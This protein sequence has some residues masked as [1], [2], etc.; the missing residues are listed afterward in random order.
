MRRMAKLPNGS[1]LATI[2]PALSEFEQAKMSKFNKKS[3][4]IFN[5]KEANSYETIN[6][7]SFDLEKAKGFELPANDL[8]K[9]AYADGSV[10]VK[11][12][13]M[14]VFSVSLPRMD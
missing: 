14:A 13:G 4:A 9:C 2:M 1:V 7:E 12:D 3:V 6:Y 5:N 11:G 10:E 8:I